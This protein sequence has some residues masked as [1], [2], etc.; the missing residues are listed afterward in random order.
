MAK[1]SHEF[2][3][4]KAI[5]ISKKSREMGNTP[6]GALIIDAD[7]NILVEQ[8]NVEMT[9]GIATG[10]AETQAIEKVSKK[11]PKDFLWNC[12]LYTTVEPCAMCA[13][14]QY[15][16]N[17]GTLVYGMT[18]RQLLSMTGDDEKNP[19]FDLPCTEVFARGQK[20]ITVIGPFPELVEEIAEVHKGYWKD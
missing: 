17:I 5:E 19:T 4:K 10:H 15:W 11:Y 18:E 12:T 9:E 1:E 20:Q 7:G 3:L 13:G 6:F 16:A 8:T 2:Y 14:A